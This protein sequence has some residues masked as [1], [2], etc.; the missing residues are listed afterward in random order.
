[1]FCFFFKSQS[2]L[3]N[4]FVLRNKVT[5]KIKGHNCPGEAPGP[6]PLGWVLGTSVRKPQVIDLCDVSLPVINFHSSLFQN[7]LML[8]PFVSERLLCKPGHRLWGSSQMA[9][10]SA[11]CVGTRPI[12]T[13]TSAGPGNFSLKFRTVRMG[14]PLTEKRNPTG[15]RT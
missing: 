15:L 1:M 2:L 14:S 9:P 12:R 4:T 10:P 11:H 7:A 13:P 5:F 6:F 8:R 3:P